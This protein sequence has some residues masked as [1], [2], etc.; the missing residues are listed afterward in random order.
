MSLVWMMARFNSAAGLHLGRERRWLRH[1]V[2][3]TI[4][5]GRGSKPHLLTIDAKHSGSVRSADNREVGGSTPSA[6]TIFLDRT[7][8]GVCS[9]LLTREADGFDPLPVLQLPQFL[10]GVGLRLSSGSR[11]VRSPSG[12][13]Y[14]RLWWQAPGFLNRGAVVRFHPR[15]PLCGCRK[16]ANPPDLGS[17]N[18]WFESSHPHHFGRRVCRAHGCPTNSKTRFDSA[19]AYQGAFFW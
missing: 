11:R 1:V 15:V 10:T 19:V 18:R 5:S 8:T 9:G 6:S 16:V 12:A 13:P 3:K 14:S 4:P 17:G 2:C 7:Q